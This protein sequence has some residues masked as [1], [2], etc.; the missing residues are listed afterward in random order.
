MDGLSD[1]GSSSDDSETP[2]EGDDGTAGKEFVLPGI[3]VAETAPEAGADDLPTDGLQNKPREVEVPVAAPS[4]KKIA[5][6]Q[7]QDQN[8]STTNCSGASSSS[9]PNSGSAVPGVNMNSISGATEGGA[10]IGGSRYKR[11]LHQP[12]HPPVESITGTAKTNSRSFSAGSSLLKRS[13]SLFSGGASA[14]TDK[15]KKSLLKRKDEGKTK[16]GRQL[17]LGGKAVADGQ[18]VHD[19]PALRR[20]AAKDALR[21]LKSNLRRAEGNSEKEKTGGISVNAP[22]RNG[23]SLLELLFGTVADLPATNLED[24]STQDWYR[25]TAGM[26]TVQKW[27]EN[28]QKH[29]YGWGALMMIHGTDEVCFRLR[30]K[31]EN[32]AVY[33]ALFLSASLVLILAPQESVSHLCEREESERMRKDG[34]VVYWDA[35]EMF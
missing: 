23:R 11:D 7:P 30:T 4:M 34:R 5:P 17:V 10:S 26:H 27:L 28:Y 19:I 15:D 24:D 13:A 32:Y 12:Q 9:P 29:P 14:V 16:D 1:A 6:E 3:E 8:S 31:V 25:K 2:D 33:A 35:S 22:V 20:Q 21:T 18:S